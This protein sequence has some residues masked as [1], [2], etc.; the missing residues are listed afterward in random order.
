M[1]CT[2]PLLPFAASA[3]DRVKR[4]TTNFPVKEAESVQ[5][6]QHIVYGFAAIKNLNKPLH[7]LTSTPKRSKLPEY[8][9]LVA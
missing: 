7:F 9:Q 2:D 3:N 1:S 6:N 4:Q 5:S 8:R